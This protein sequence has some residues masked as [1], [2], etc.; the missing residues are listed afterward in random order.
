MTIPIIRDSSCRTPIVSMPTRKNVQLTVSVLLTLGFFACLAFSLWSYCVVGIFILAVVITYLKKRDAKTVLLL[1]SP[2]LVY[3]ALH[4]LL[5]LF[6]A[7]FLNVK[8]PF[9]YNSSFV[10]W[11]YFL[12]PILTG[13]IY[14]YL[15]RNILSGWVEPKQRKAFVGFVCVL[16]AAS[17]FASRIASECWDVSR[18]EK[19]ITQQ[20]I[21]WCQF[22][23]EYHPTSSDDFSDFPGQLQMLT[24]L[25][26]SIILTAMVSLYFSKRPK[27]T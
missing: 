20:E 14:A 13:L 7:R 26:I 18:A 11:G 25:P 21:H 17:L 10:F 5:V 24:F 1:L 23:H 27:R 2:I 6:D 12:P 22:V 16:I 15:F 19:G 8:Y 3:P 4:L 9:I